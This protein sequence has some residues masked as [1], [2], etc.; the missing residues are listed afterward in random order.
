MVSSYLLMLDQLKSVFWRDGSVPKWLSPLGLSVRAK[1][2][3]PELRIPTA[4]SKVP[5]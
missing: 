4:L 5:D 3:G 2:V 1:A